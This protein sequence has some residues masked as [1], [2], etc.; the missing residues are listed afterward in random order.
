MTVGGFRC[1]EPLD[2]PFVTLWGLLPI[3]DLIEEKSFSMRSMYWSDT[4]QK[5]PWCIVVFFSPGVTSASLSLI[6]ERTVCSKIVTLIR[7]LS[8]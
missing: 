3:S 1:T 2:C 6:S 8:I 4:R 5:R 7:T